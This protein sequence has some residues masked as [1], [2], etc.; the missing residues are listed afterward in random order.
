MSRHPL[1]P[2]VLTSESDL[3]TVAEA[4]AQLRISR[5]TF[6]RLVQTRQLL[7][8][9]IGSA[10]RVPRTAIAEFIADLSSH[11]DAV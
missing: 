4:C 10:R 3:L 9:K 8:V 6:Y 11:Q 2:L 5:W 1:Q 7:T